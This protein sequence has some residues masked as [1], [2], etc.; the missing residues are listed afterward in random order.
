MRARKSCEVLVV[1]AGPV[2]MFTALRLA[3]NGVDVCVVD[4]ATGVASQSYACGL[5]PRTLSL[6]QSAGLETQVQPWGRRI[7]SVAFY[8]GCERR[9]EIDLSKLSA[10]YPFLLVLPEMRI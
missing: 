7:G 6:L 10:P 4:E 8:E 2:G 3:Q 9:G 5:H 1:G